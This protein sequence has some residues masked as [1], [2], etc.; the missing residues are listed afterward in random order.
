[1]GP[2][3]FTSHPR[4]RCAADFYRPQK[5][6]ALAGFEPVIFGSS[7]KHTNHYIT[8]APEKALLTNPCGHLSFSLMSSLLRQT[9]LT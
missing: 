4:G 3:G 5:T 9:H 6:I 7:G 2:S 8:K 1:M